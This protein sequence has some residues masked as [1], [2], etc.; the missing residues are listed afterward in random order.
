MKRSE[1][2]IGEHYRFRGE[3]YA[4]AKV[5]EILP[6]KTGKNTTRKYIAKCHWDIKKNPNF[7]IIKYFAVADLTN[8]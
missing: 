6:P 8:K 4:W 1:V 7:A 5:V 2:I 3:T